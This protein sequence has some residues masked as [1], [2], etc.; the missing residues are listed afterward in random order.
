ML[1]FFHLI[2]PLSHSKS[3]KINPLDVWKIHLVKNLPDTTFS[4]PILLFL[5]FFV[6]VWWLWN[7]SLYIYEIHIIFD[8]NHFACFWFSRLN[9][10]Q[11]SLNIFFCFNLFDHLVVYRNIL[12]RFIFILIFFLMLIFDRELR[13][14]WNT[15]FRIFKI[16][17]ILC[18][19]F[20][21]FQVNVFNFIFVNIVKKFCIFRWFY[22]SIQDL[23]LKLL[24]FV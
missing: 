4:K 18:R 9:F 1:L 15:W 7:F 20:W 8:K 14:P 5:S 21:I 10:L 11:P 16:I 12:R 6:E 23:N 2:F 17:E 3:P 13:W 24:R 22:L 19:V